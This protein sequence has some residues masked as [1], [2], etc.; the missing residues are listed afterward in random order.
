M[1]T[2]AHIDGSCTTSTGVGGIG[3][4]ILI[5][6]KKIIICHG[7][8]KNTT[9]NR[10]ELFAFIYVIEYLKTININ[11]VKVYSD[12]QYLVNGYNKWI[13][14]WIRNNWKNSE[15]K[16]VLNIDLWKI[17]LEI[18]NSV[19]V[20]LEWERGHTNNYYNNLV[21]YLAKTA[22]KQ[23]HF[24]GEIENKNENNLSIY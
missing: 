21:D 10:M 13:Y 2:I 22:C 16:D 5:G 6:N 3:G 14:S 20:N 18:T 11:K 23:V 7:A 15:G 1:I 9:N 12:S 19:C 17:I 8:F 4:I 24:I